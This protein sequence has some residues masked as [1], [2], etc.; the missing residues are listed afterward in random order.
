MTIMRGIDIPPTSRFSVHINANSAPGKCCACGSAGD[1]GRQ[2]IDFGMQLDWYGAVYFCTF[3]VTELCAAAGFVHGDV[4]DEAA[5]K[6]RDAITE[7]NA[8]ES[9]FRDY[10]DATR[11]L[12]RDCNCRD[13]ASSGNVPM[14]RESSN[15]I[16]KGTTAKSTKRSA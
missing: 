10:R 8:T 4:F 9:S 16:P 15:D 3:C 2:F 5:T 11:I 1:D 6:L 14:A 7:L 13:D 12:L